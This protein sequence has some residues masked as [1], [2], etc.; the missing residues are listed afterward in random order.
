MSVDCL[1]AV[2]A[3]GFSLDRGSPHEFRCAFEPLV[4]QLTG[5]FSASFSCRS[6]EEGAL[7]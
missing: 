5:V 7:I 1:T 6:R 2:D 3:V 4:F